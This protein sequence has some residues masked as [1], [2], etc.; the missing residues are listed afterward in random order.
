MSRKVFPLAP[1]PPDKVAPRASDDRLSHDPHVLR[2]G[3]E[4][5]LGEAQGWFDASSNDDAEALARLCR[6]IEGSTLLDASNPDTLDLQRVRLVARVP[7]SWGDPL[8]LAGIAVAVLGMAADTIDDEAYA[9]RYIG[10]ARAALRIAENLDAPR[11][12]RASQAAAA[13]AAKRSR[14]AIELAR[15]AQAWQSLPK[16]DK[17]EAKKVALAKRFAKSESTIE[18]WVAEARKSGLL[19]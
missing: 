12:H 18:R 1:L 7:R 14:H 4:E 8:L 5:L 6:A 9:V 16:G 13:A 10:A 3:L 11:V 2:P 19:D 17:F 15:F